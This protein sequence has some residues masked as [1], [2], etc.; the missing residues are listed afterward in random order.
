LS[1]RS[2]V[3]Q[4]LGA[5]GFYRARLA[6][7]PYSGVAVL[8]Y[9]GI[10]DDRASRPTHFGEL[11]VTAARL[12]SHL[13]MMRSLDCT[14]IGWTEWCDIATGLRPLPPRAVMV[15]F[16]DGYRSVL[17]HA[18]PMLQDFN[19]PAVVF[20]CTAPVERRVRFWF[21]ALAEQGEDAVERA[22]SM[23]HAEWRDLI[24]AI[25]MPVLADDPHAPMSIDEVR[26]LAS[27]RGITIGAHTMTHPILSRAD[28]SE[29]RAE[30]RGCRAS[31]EAWVNQPVT[32]FAYPNG[33]SAID[34]TPDTEREVDAAGFT[35]AFATDSGFADPSRSRLAH[36]RFLMLDTVEASELAHRL[37][38]SWPAAHAAAN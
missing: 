22:K 6:S 3:K 8:A 12:A 37:A 28:V 31:L 35:H 25:E 15:T 29:Q 10:R 11:H 2:L 4:T 33:R 34:F 26:H 1:L 36:P 13:E 5:A 23:G 27:Q 38:V 9:H 20:V 14:F 30:L 16:D 7:Q 21:D 19:V 18:L 17:T 24:E 32:A